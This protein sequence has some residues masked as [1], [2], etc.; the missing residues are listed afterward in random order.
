MALLGA[1]AYFYRQVTY[2]FG[3]IKDIAKT[4]FVLF[5]PKHKACFFHT[6]FV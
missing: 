6:I 5:L 3:F 2:S 4:I 1:F